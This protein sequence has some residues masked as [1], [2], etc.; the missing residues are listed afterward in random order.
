M[1]AS[2]VGVAAN[3]CDRVLRSRDCFWRPSDFDG[4]PEAVVQALHRLRTSGELLHVRRGLYWRGTKTLLGMAPPPADALVKA[5]ASERRGV[6]PAGAS[7]ANALGLSTQVPR[8]PVFAVPTRVPESMP[9]GVDMVSRAGCRNRVT[10]NARPAEVALLEV[11]RDWSALV[12]VD[13][14]EATGIIKSH[15][16]H[17][18][19]RAS[20]LVKTAATEPAPVRTRLATLLANCGYRRDAVSTRGAAPLM[21]VVPA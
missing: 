4:S 12:E 21:G 1:S 20:A 6:G 13:D 17:G 10:A 3:V 19:L 11:L 9:A 7:A 5:V 2:R 16:D 18:A 8:R 15:L 14:A